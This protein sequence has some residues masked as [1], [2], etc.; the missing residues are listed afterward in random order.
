MSNILH[1]IKNTSTTLAAT[2]TNISFSSP[3]GI[4]HHA[5]LSV[6]GLSSDFTGIYTT[7]YSKNYVTGSPLSRKYLSD[8]SNIVKTI[9]GYDSTTLVVNNTTNLVT[10][11]EGSGVY[12]GRYIVSIT[13]ATWLLMSNTPSAPP[14]PGASITFSTSSYEIK[15][16]TPSTTSGIG[17]GWYINGNGYSTSATVL[18]VKSS[19]TLVVDF[20]PTS[21]SVGNPLTFSTSTKINYVELD[22]V[23]SLSIGQKAYGNGY[24][25][26]SI[27][28]IAGNIVTMSGLPN[29]YP[30]VG[31][32][33]GFGTGNIYT[34]P[35]SSEVGFN[36]DFTKS[37]STTGTYTSITSVDIWQGVDN[38]TYYFTNYIVISSST[39]ALPSP[40]PTNAISDIYFDNNNLGLGYGL[41]YISP[42]PNA[43]YVPNTGRLEPAEI[44]DKSSGFVSEVGEFEEQRLLASGATAA[45]SLLMFNDKDTFGDVSSVNDAAIK[46]ALFEQ[47]YSEYRSITYQQLQAAN[48]LPSQSQVDY[49]LLRDEAQFQAQQQA[50]SLKI[51][52]Q[53]SGIIVAVSDSARSGLQKIIADNVKNGITSENNYAMAALQG[54]QKV[55]QVVGEG[56]NWVIERL[57]LNS[58]GNLSLNSIYTSVKEFNLNSVSTGF[59]NF[60]NNNQYVSYAIKTVQGFVTD[61]GKS[62]QGL[63]PGINLGFTDNSNRVGGAAAATSI[64]GDPFV[65]TGIAIVST[66]MSP[67][68]A[69][70]STLASLAG[71]QVGPTGEIGAGLARSLS[72][73]TISS[74]FDSISTF[75]S[76]TAKS[77]DGFGKTITETFDRLFGNNQTAL[78]ANVDALRTGNGVGSILGGLD[79]RSLSTTLNGLDTNISQSTGLSKVWETLSNFGTSILNNVTDWATNL[80]TTNSVATS[81]LAIVSASY[82]TN[83]SSAATISAI[84]GTNQ[85]TR[86]SVIAALAAANATGTGR[87][88]VF[89]A[90]ERAGIDR[91]T[92]ANLQASAAAT[93]NYEGTLYNNTTVTKNVTKD[94]Y[95]DTPT[96]TSV[97]LSYDSFAPT[98]TN[99]GAF[100][101]PIISGGGGDSSGSVNVNAR[102]PGTSKLAGQ[103]I[104][105]DALVLLAE[106]RQGTIP[107]V[108]ISNTISE[109][110]LLTMVSE[111]GIKLT[112]SDNTPLTLE[113]GSSI[114]ST[115]VLGKKLP[116]EDQNGFRWELIVEVLDAGHGKVA[117]IYCEDQCY[118]AGDEPGRWIWTHNADAIK[119]GDFAANF[120]GPDIYGL[121][122]G[123]N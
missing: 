23:T 67:T 123:N 113:D 6:F 96:S 5:D 107:G 49:K 16:Q 26:Q 11:W 18:S 31:D 57:S 13:S 43:E 97:S 100:G 121:N 104:H 76:N 20:L 21:P 77:F 90:A 60:V 118:A 78:A 79:G 102:M 93:V 9:S 72:N 41:A 80:F 8:T 4:Q 86:E 89:D 39:Y 34:I 66:L 98:T 105:G 99:L 44:I 81:G 55:I 119:Y 58:I 101:E 70:L 48:M 85:A 109:Q 46:T 59:N 82:S 37:I 62:L 53:Q 88:I 114:N 10:G 14:T 83:M 2:I 51:T 38:S 92:L 45:A 33:I 35:A 56:I 91:A 42:F 19:D 24:S 40:G 94:P 116:V 120:D 115:E 12:S 68:T 32:P 95:E 27:V 29:T 106:D 54:V 30:V 28:N 61:I 103:M 47:Q 36:L 52:A 22:S 50:N 3:A 25:G 73:L 75:I 111:S 1:T 69:I 84:A 117:T 110:R 65:K 7:A 112:C 17:P 108:V 63:V 74:A 87:E 71:F 15:L 64:F 122:L